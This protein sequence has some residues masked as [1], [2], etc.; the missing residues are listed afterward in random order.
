VQP[1]P[2]KTLVAFRRF[3]CRPSHKSNAR[4]RFDSRNQV[5]RHGLGKARSSHH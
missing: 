1:N 4:T 2:L 3:D 5:S